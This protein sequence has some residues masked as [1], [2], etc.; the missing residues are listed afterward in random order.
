MRNSIFAGVSAIALTLMTIAPS[1]ATAENFTDSQ[2]IGDWAAPSVD[3]LVDLGV[4]VGYPDGSFN[5][6]WSITRQEYAVSLLKGLEVLNDQITTAY[7]AEDAELYQMLI[8]QQ[9]ELLGALADIDE[10]KAAAAVQKNNYFA[11]SMVYDFEDSVTNDS[12]YISLDGKLQVVKLSNKL[13][14][15][16]RPFINTTGEAGG[17]ATLDYKV[18]DKVTLSAGAGAAGSW[19]TNGALTGGD[20]VVGYGQGVVDYSV[21]KDTVVTA[22]VKVPFTG[23]NSGNVQTSV[24]VGVKW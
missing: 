18:S 4:L 2:Y 9:V 10:L 1:F 16:V 23:P 14:I 12:G 6:D 17:A 13:A 24:G 5:P 7:E 21:S 8:D 19:S 20:D 22:G 15:S 11:L 3:T